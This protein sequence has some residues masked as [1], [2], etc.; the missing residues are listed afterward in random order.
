MPKDDMSLIVYKLLRYIYGCN[1]S[2]K[3]TTFSEMF[4]ALEL[5]NI[6]QSYLAQI[7]SELLN[8]GYVKGILITPTKSGT[9]ITVTNEAYIT[10]KG[11]DF[12]NENSRMKKAAEIAGKAFEVLL[13]GIVSMA[14]TL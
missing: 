11:T 2:G 5:G 9:A 3:A 14:T 7:L 13:S 8:E 10:L 1:K 6:P 12:L 4:T